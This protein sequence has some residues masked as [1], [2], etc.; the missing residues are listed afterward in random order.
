MYTQ[1]LNSSEGED[2]NV[3]DAARAGQFQARIDAEER[4]E[5]NDWMPAAYRKTLTRQISQHAHSEIIGM[6]P[7]GNWLTRAPS[8]RRK[9][10]LLAKARGGT[11]EAFWQSV[12]VLQKY[13]AYRNLCYI[14]LPNNSGEVRHVYAGAQFVRGRRPQH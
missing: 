2:R 4:I 9:A 8:L 11:C 5:P 3:E 10:A 1:A 7:E 12:N 6:Q 14:L 13:I